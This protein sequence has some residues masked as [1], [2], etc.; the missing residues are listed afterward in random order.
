MTRSQ[1]TY[2]RRAHARYTDPLIKRE[3][4]SIIEKILIGAVDAVA[5]KE[6]RLQQI[7]P[8]TRRA[9]DNP[10]K[11]MA[12]PHAR[13]VGAPKRSRS[14]T[15]VTAGPRFRLGRKRRLVKNS[16]HGASNVER[17]R[18]GEAKLSAAENPGL[19]YPTGKGHGRRRA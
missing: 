3:K 2:G 4:E 5:L 11:R 1:S 17:E 6:K 10:A 9:G 14:T 12:T 13:C 19:L 7:K 16:T 8:E 15:L 18:S